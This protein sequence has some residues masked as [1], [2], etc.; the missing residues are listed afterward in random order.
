MDR[1]GGAQISF[2]KQRNAA[3]VV[4]MLEGKKRKRGR[5]VTQNVFLWM[6]GELFLPELTKLELVWSCRAG[7]W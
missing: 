5:M 6:W 2:C 7:E 4:T 3:M 1:C